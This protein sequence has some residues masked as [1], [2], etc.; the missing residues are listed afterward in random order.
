MSHPV[1]RQFLADM[2]EMYVSGAIFREREWHDSHIFDVVM[3]RYPSWAEAFKNISEDV[4]GNHV[5]PETVLGKAMIHYKGPEAKEKKET[6]IKT[7]NCVPDKNIRANIKY[8]TEVFESLVQV[9]KPHG[10][11]AVF[12][13]A[14]PS[15]GENIEK[16]RE[17]SAK[18][19]VICVKHSHDYLIDNGIVPW[20]CVLLDPRS[21]VKD[22]IEN[23]HPDVKYICSSMV[24]PTTVDRLNEKKAQVLLYHASVNAGE[25]DLFAGPVISGGSASAFRGLHVLH[26]MGFRSFELFGFDACYQDKQDIPEGKA[27]VTVTLE[28]TDYLT[29]TEMLAQKQDL[30][31]FMQLHAPKLTVHGDGLLAHVFSIIE[32]EKAD[33]L[34]VYG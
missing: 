5:W 27:I 7:V 17:L 19:R 16:I 6:R 28:D 13:S 15:L 20:G 14:G 1:V 32:R 10:E 3:S 34:N 29:T 24:H 2:R 21:H 25:T 23:P 4:P 12:C 22:F 33:F 8:S 18:H 9:C 26:A 31:A 11:L 30:E